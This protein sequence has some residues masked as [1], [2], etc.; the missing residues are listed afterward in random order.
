[1]PEV[2]QIGAWFALI[3]LVLM[4]QG[5]GDDDRLTLL[6]EGGCRTAD[7]GHGTHETFSLSFDECR[8]RCLGEG[9]QCTAIEYSSNTRACEVHSEP[10]TKFEKAEGVRCYI[11]IK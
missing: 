4:A 10:I 8:Q 7:N 1:M 3:G 11:V 9:E 2:G 5:C 6:G